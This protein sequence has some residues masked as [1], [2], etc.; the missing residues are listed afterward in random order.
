[1]IDREETLRKIKLK[2]GIAE[3]NT[4]ND[5]LIILMISDAVEAVCVYCHRSDFPAPLEYLIREVVCKTISDDNAGNVASIKRGDTQI[6]YNTSITADSYTDRQRAAM[7]AYR[8]C[9][10]I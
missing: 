7:N 8:T 2:Q 6:N 1:M 4:E 9:R 10:C 5:A 3:E